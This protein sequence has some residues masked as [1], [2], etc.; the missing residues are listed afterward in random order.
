LS[1]VTCEQLV[2]H[3]ITNS[4]N[5]TIWLQGYYSGRNGNTVVDTQAFRANANKLK[6][7]CQLNSNVTVM[8]AGETILGR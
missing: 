2:L 5:I 1:K 6:R 3:R 4:E 8:K 7:Y